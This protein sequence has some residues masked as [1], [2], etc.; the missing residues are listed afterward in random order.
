[1][2]HQVIAIGR[3]GSEPTLKYLP[4]GTAVANFSVAT[5]RRYKDSSG[6]PVVETTWLRVSVFGKLAEVCSQYLTKGKL[7]HVQGRLRSDKN[8]NPVV[9]TASDGTSKSSH[10]LIGETVTFL[11]P[12]GEPEGAP[13]IGSDEDTPGEDIPF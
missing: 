11:S 12:K 8:G 6:K 4:S 10:E 13:H 2:F 5:D 1:M 3:L 7:V 9:Y